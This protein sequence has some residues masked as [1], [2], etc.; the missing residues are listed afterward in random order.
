MLLVWHLCYKERKYNINYD[1]NF[2]RNSII[3]KSTL[4]ILYKSS[5]DNNDEKS[6]KNNN[7]ADNDRNNNTS[8]N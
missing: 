3:M 1:N 5:N 8:A 2:T 4:R 6:N 7:D